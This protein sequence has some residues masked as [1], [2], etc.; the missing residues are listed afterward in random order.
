MNETVNLTSEQLGGNKDQPENLR[1][2]WITLERKRSLTAQ[3]VGEQSSKLAV[4]YVISELSA[5][6]WKG[7]LWGLQIY[8]RKM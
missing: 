7:I 2:R 1:L 3:Y 4:S 5:L 6:C 8:G